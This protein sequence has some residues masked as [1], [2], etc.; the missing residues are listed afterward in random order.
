MEPLRLTLRLQPD[1]FREGIFC[2][3]GFLYYKWVLAFQLDNASAIAKSL[4]DAK[5][6]GNATIE[7]KIFLSQSRERLPTSILR[8]VA[9]VRTMLK[10]YDDAFDQ[11]TQAANPV[12]F[13]DFL[14]NA[15][16]VFVRVGDQLG[17]LQHVIS[18]WR[19]RHLKEGCANT[20]TAPELIDVLKDFELSIGGA[21][22]RLI[23]SEAA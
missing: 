5:Y 7:E 8:S 10:E 17:A 16:A 19:Y 15:P 23:R 21:E 18:F 22:Q 3:K 9:S 13:R 6:V 2:W 14:L 11:L 20:M 1:Q 4:R 12:S